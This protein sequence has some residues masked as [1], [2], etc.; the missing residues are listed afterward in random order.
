MKSYLVTGAAGFIGSKVAERLI[1]LGH[2]VV[3][4]DNLSTGYS[5]AIPEGVI[6]IEGN[7]HDIEVIKKLT[8]FT[9][10]TIYHIAGQSSGEISF[11][12]PVY[13]LQTNTQS[14]LL[15][16]KYC[17]SIKCRKFIYA[18]TM[19]VY[20]DQETLP[21]SEMAL[22]YPKSLYGVGKLASEHYL[23]IYAQ[24]GIATCALRL[25]N[26]YGP[27]QNLANMR[28]GMV[29]IFLAQ[30]LRDRAIH[31][32]GA[33]DRFRDFVYIDDVVDAFLS[34]EDYIQVGEYSCF[35]VCSG[36]K[37]TVGE[38][39]DSIGKLFEYPVSVTY[40]GATP[41]DQFGIVGNNQ[42]L[43]SGIFW[44][45]EVPLGEGLSRMFEWANTI[46]K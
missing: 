32:K 42:S 30:A 23:R 37:T 15:L 11:D 45:P 19:S 26:V 5:S 41:G 31:V 27:G 38:L 44:Q 33:A 9:F 25:F 7:L 1:R 46:R 14:T 21:V 28:Q 3:T 4:V 10:D 13:D 24:Y 2:K 35:N 40:Q 12:D 17:L 29:S 20:G 43:Q 34:I 8:E 39:V 6:F 22:T 16:L 18:S 36:I